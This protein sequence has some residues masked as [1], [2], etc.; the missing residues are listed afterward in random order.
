M[1]QVDLSLVDKMAGLAQINPNNFG[2]NVLKQF[3]SI[4]RLVSRAAKAMQTRL[5][6]RLNQSLEFPNL[7]QN[8]TKGK[9]AK[10]NLLK[11]RQLSFLASLELYAC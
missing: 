10:K 7:N 5:G 4:N 11:K 6:S 9:R 1:I 8:H 2:L 3:I